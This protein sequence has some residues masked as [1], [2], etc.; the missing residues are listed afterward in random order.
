MGFFDLFKKNTIQE[1][2]IIQT[3]SSTQNSTVPLKKTQEKEKM[4]LD[5]FDNDVK[6]IIEILKTH[7]CDIVSDASEI[8][9]AYDTS[10]FS[11]YRIIKSDGIYLYREVVMGGYNLEKR[12]DCLDISVS[13]VILCADILLGMKHRKMICD[14]DTNYQKILEIMANYKSK[15]NSS[16]S[17]SDT[18]NFL[19]NRYNEL[20]KI[21]T[22]S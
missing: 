14:S 2:N 19:V 5:S 17:N 8:K 4:L 1:T 22:I 12:L 15:L 13:F 3:E 9:I 10:W 20:M 6:T 16:I 7:G 21:S 18:Q 11:E